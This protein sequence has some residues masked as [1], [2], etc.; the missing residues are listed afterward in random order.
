MVFWFVFGVVVGLLWLWVWLG[1]GLVF[2]GFVLLCGVLFFWV[3]VFC[4]CFGCVL[5]FVCCGWWCCCCGW[6]F[7]V[8]GCV[9]VWGC[10]CGA[11][12]AGFCHGRTRLVLRPRD[13]ADRRVGLPVADCR[14]RTRQ[15]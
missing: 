9:W 13:L 2:F 7:L 5:C 12:G 10:G 4:F 3:F 11:G 6:G 8:W 1:V 14:A 15:T